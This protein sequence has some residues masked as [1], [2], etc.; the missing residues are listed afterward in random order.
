MFEQ[1]NLTAGIVHHG[2]NGID[3][4]SAGLR[5]ARSGRHKPTVGQGANGRNIIVEAK[6]QHVVVGLGG[7]PLGKQQGKEEREKIFH[8]RDVFGQ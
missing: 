2:K 4:Q 6:T 8:K 5:R 3:E 1:Q 7:K